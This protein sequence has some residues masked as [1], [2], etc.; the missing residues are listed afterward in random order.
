MGPHS[1]GLNICPVPSIKKHS[2]KELKLKDLEKR[3]SIALSGQNDIT[4]SEFGFPH[5]RRY[6]IISNTGIQSP[7]L[8]L[9]QPQ[10]T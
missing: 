7:K 6:F 10:W 4:E 9:R 2:S 1:T 8:H 5:S 3:E